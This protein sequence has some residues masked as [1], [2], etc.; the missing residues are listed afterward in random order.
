MVLRLDGRVRTW[1]TRPRTA[2]WIERITGAVFLGL[3]LR[4]ALPGPDEIPDLT[5]R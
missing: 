5:K 1:L 4:L 2:S 3:G